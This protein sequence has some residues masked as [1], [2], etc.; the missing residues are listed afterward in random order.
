MERA[1]TNYIRAL[2]TAGAAVSPGEAI[3]AARALAVVGYADRQ[4][5][6]NT[7]SVVLAKTVEEKELHDGLF[8]L[9][10]SRG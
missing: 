9:Y 6:K 2:R 8:D 7:L 1:L 5:M 10:F 4:T 3:D